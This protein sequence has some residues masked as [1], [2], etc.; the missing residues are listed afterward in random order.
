MQDVS[1]SLSGRIGIIELS[2]LSM[3]ECMGDAFNKHFLPTLEYV[4]ERK[5]SLQKPKNIWEIIHMGGY[6]ELQDEEKE[7]SAFYADYV[8][9]YIE[10]DVRELAD[11][12]DLNVFRQF[13]IA[14]AAR[15]GEI[16]NYSTD[17][18]SLREII[19][20]FCHIF[21]PFLSESS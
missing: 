11:V 15:T 21:L 19:L 20:V 8:R 6:P 18:A 7:W 5:K 9:T 16:L 1:D 14:A 2:G 4:A 10:R 17:N 12:Q 13:M 3:R